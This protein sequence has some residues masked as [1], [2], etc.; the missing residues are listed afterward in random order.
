MAALGDDRQS[1]GGRRV[2]GEI[3]VVG[4][5]LVSELDQGILKGAQPFGGSSAIAVP[6]ELMLGFQP[7]ILDEAPE[8]GDQGLPQRRFLAGIF[9]RK[10]I[11]LPAQS[12]EV[13]IRGLGDYRLVHG[14]FLHATLA[15]DAFKPR[16]RPLATL[17]GGKGPPEPVWGSWRRA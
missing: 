7:G 17:S 6:L 12:G 11:G 1:F 13:E 3:D 15:R 4:G 2:L 16:H 10:L 8:A 14:C 5:E 9:P